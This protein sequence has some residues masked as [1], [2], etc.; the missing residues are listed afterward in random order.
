[1]TD[2]TKPIR[3]SVQGKLITIAII[4]GLSILL[5]LSVG[6]ILTPF[7]AAIITAYIFNPL[8]TF[9]QDRMPVRRSFWI[10]V[11]YILAF[12]LLYGVGTWI[13]P[14][15]LYQYEELVSKLP[16][17]VASI[18]ETLSQQND[19]ELGIGITIDLQPVQ[20]QII[21]AVSELGRTLSGSVPH[22]VFSALETAFYALVYLIVT[23]Y[24]LLQSREL[25]LWVISLIPPHYRDEICNLGNQIDH[26]LNA[27]IRGQILLVLIMS[28][29]TYI[30]LSILKVP[31]ALVI[32]FASGVLELIP[33]LGPWSAAGIA[34]TVAFFQ[35][36]IPFGLSSLALTGLIGAIYFTLR[37]F[38]DSFIIPNVVGHL[39]KLHPAVVIFAVLAGGTVAGALGLLIAIPIAAVMRILLT[40]IYAKLLDDNIP[41]PP[42]TTATAEEEKLAESSPSQTTPSD[43][44]NT[45]LSSTSST[46]TTG[47]RAEV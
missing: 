18:T 3:L 28:V 36:D 42:D 4:V 29:L 14:R 1:M 44:D 20:E 11:L 40:Y 26:V 7:I 31:Y 24:L 34:M 27:Y 25:S 17:F 45:A 30:P 2:Q 47:K 33:I 16:D 15:I 37:Q 13:W 19:I 9:L 38:E 10:V 12:S 32:A 6:P 5:I 41:P 46:S 43:Q 21:N 22:L 23:F 8:I 39:V 35:T